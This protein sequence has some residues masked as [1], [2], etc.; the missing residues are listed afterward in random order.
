LEQ[1][2]G[3]LASRGAYDEARTR[4][5]ALVRLLAPRPASAATAPGAGPGRG[6]GRTWVPG[7]AGAARAAA[8]SRALCRL[9]AVEEAQGEWP[10][11]AAAYG[12]AVAAS[13]VPR[14]PPDA[15]P[16][17]NATVAAAAAVAGEEG[18][19]VHAAA[20]CGAAVARWAMAP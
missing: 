6:P 2:A 4:L 19:G 7:P 17:L 8:R 18:R 3:L 13:P 1:L 9:G 20:L 14:L 12:A 10:A 11:A 15:P 16:H 5:R